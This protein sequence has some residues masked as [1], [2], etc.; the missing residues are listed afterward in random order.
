MNET[1]ERRLIM[2]VDSD[3]ITAC[4]GESSISQEP[5]FTY[6]FVTVIRTTHELGSNLY[7]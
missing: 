4:G 5:E 6:Y 2:V 7:L 3:D 1:Q